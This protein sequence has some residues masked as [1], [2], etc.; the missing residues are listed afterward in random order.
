VWHVTES[1]EISAPPE[2]VWEVVAD[3]EGHARLA[4]SGEVRAIRFDGPLE[5]GATFEGDIATGEVGSFVSRNVIHEVDRPSRL[6]WR[7]YPPLDEDETPDHQIEV[8][9]SFT[10]TLSSAGTDVTHGFQV[11]R[12]KAGADELQ[13]FLDRTN[14]I[15]TVGQGM[16]RTLENL[17]RAA[18]VSRQ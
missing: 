10:L 16:R 17:K 8:I 7:S 12:P 14:R 6:V 9:W 5:P 3:I 4:G 11:P 13:A 15:E 18:D 2:A 1:I